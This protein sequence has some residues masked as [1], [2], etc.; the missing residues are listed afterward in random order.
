[1]KRLFS[2]LFMTSLLCIFYGKALEQ[3]ERQ[4]INYFNIG[5]LAAVN[6]VMHC[7]HAVQ[8]AAS[9][10]HEIDVNTALAESPAQLVPVLKSYSKAPI[11]LQKMHR[12]LCKSMGLDHTKIH[13]KLNKAQAKGVY[14]NSIVKM[15][16][17]DKPFLKES[18]AQQVGVLAH[19]LGH[20]KHNDGKN[21]LRFNIATSYATTLGSYFLGYVFHTPYTT[22]LQENVMEL[23]ESAYSRALERRAD[24]EAAQVVGG[25][26]GLIN[27][28]EKDLDQDKHHTVFSTHPTF[29]ER[30]E[31]LQPYVPQGK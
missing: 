23:L 9:A 10:Q 8:H 16:V 13:L 31:K 14:C 12:T 1:M 24:N 22:T 29:K 17:I 28:L 30:I 26:Q 7:T 20:I 18:Y 2:T 25:A 27:Y 11:K 5:P 15:V 6:F 21:Q 3:Q 4:S 19:E